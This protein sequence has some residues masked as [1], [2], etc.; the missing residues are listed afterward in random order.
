MPSP[1]HCHSPSLIHFHPHALEIVI[2]T[3]D[4]EEIGPREGDVLQEKRIPPRNGRLDRQSRG[5]QNGAGRGREG[6]EAGGKGDGNGAGIGEEMQGGKEE[7]E[8]ESLKGE[9][10]C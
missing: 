3:C 10:H 5:R 7:E 4:V 2:P 9:K 8:D 1:P 6:R